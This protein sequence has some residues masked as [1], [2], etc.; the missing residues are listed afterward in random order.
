MPTMLELL[1]GKV[2]HYN[3]VNNKILV[4]VRFIGRDP[5]IMA[6]ITP[7]LPGDTILKGHIVYGVD[8]LLHTSNV[9]WC[10]LGCCLNRTKQFDLIYPD[11]KCYEKTD[12]LKHEPRNLNPVTI[13]EYEA[14][15]S[16]ARELIVENERMKDIN[17][18]LH[19]GETVILQTNPVNPISYGLT[20]ANIL[21]R[22]HEQAKGK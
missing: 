18:R 11:G 17:E 7:P 13:A 12:Y 8:L 21:L 1:S 22:L 16:M 10:D 15:I 2:L 20:L 9:E 3:I 4:P 6:M 19:R 14:A 5:I